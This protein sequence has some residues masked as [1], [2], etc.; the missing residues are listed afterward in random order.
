MTEVTAEMLDE[1]YDRATRGKPMDYACREYGHFGCA[2]SEG[3][4][5]MGEAA[6]RE[7]AK[8]EEATT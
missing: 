3:G 5:C 7:L 6:D 1:A 2:T 8:M 4:R